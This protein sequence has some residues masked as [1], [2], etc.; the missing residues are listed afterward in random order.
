MEAW[1]RLRY[2]ETELG[3]VMM[4]HQEVDVVMMP[5]EHHIVMMRKYFFFLSGFSLMNIHVSQDSRG[6]ER[7][8]L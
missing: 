2:R 3:A 6:R 7:L 5:D 4:I 8:F 1:V